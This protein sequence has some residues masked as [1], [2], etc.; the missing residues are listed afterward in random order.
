MYTTVDKTLQRKLKIGVQ[1][2]YDVLLCNAM[3]SLRRVWR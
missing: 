1:N 2:V 3:L